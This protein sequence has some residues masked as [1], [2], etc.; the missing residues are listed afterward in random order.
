MQHL[1][2]SMTLN[3]ILGS[4][5]DFIDL[6]RSIFRENK[7][8]QYS[9]CELVCP[10]RNPIGSHDFDLKNIYSKLSTNIK[11]KRRSKSQQFNHLNSNRQESVD[12]SNQDINALTFT[13][14]FYYS[15]KYFIEFHDIESIQIVVKKKLG[16][17]FTDHYEKFEKSTIIIDNVSFDLKEDENRLDLNKNLESYKNTMKLTEDGARFYKNIFQNVSDIVTACRNTESGN[18]NIYKIFCNI[19]SIRLF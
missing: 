16:K 9:N 2:S 8:N 13:L 18:P 6:A 19:N 11:T 5:E 15:L 1:L 4:K 14:L 17:S 3:V 7:W 12:L 10:P